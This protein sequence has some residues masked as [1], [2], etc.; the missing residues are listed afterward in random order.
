MIHSLPLAWHDVRRVMWSPQQ[1]RTMLLIPEARKALE[2]WVITEV[3]LL[4][5]EECCQHQKCSGLFSPKLLFLR[6]VG[7]KTGSESCTALL[8]FQAETFIPGIGKD[9]CTSR[10]WGQRRKERGRGIPDRKSVI[11]LRILFNIFW[12]WQFGYLTYRIW[13]MR[14]FESA[15]FHRSQW[16]WFGYWFGEG[17]SVVG[18]FVLLW[19]FFLIPSECLTQQLGWGG[20]TLQ[21]AVFWNRCA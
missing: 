13:A 11:L 8:L 17:A 16:D 7:W 5:T 1:L 21:F 20:H 4:P 2:L 9:Q 12:F 19:V 6:N 14:G 10:S 3:S 15:S 18:L